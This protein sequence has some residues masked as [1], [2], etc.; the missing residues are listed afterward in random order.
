MENPQGRGSAAEI[1]AA[2]A[3]EHLV[4]FGDRGARAL[5]VGPDRAD[6]REKIGAGFDERRTILLRDAADRA[7]RHDRRL[8]PVAEQFGVGVVLGG[9]GRARKKG[10]KGDVVGANLG[11][12]DGAVAAGTQVTPTIRSG[13]NSPRASV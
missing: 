3:G 1:G 10:A 9:L 5:R 6:D 12:G 4:E 8:A 11:G 2:V 13:P 7:T